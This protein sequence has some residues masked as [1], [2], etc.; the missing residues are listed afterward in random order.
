MF[1]RSPQLQSR[2]AYQRSMG[3]SHLL[4]SFFRVSTSAGLLDR[5]AAAD[6]MV[7]AA[8]AAGSGCLSATQPS[9]GVH[10]SRWLQYVGGSLSEIHFQQKSKLSILS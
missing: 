10:V 8:S 3:L 2:V 9:T 6:D 1:D 5:A 4:S 7:E